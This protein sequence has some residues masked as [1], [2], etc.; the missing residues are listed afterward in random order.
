MFLLKINC[1]KRKEKS[2]VL[3]AKGYECLI[4]MADMSFEI[5]ATLLESKKGRK[6]LIKLGNTS[7]KPAMI[8]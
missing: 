2:F 7:V 6:I 8:T 4:G 1:L 3:N 5:I